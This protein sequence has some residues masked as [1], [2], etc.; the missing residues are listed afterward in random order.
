MV[1]EILYLFQP[2]GDSRKDVRTALI[3][4][5]DWRSMAH[6]YLALHYS[7]RWFHMH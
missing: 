1:F 2:A 4:P 7:D 5:E 6:M 3:G